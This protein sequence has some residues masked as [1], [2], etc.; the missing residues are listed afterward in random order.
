MY[1]YIACDIKIV[2]V[3]LHR[4]RHIALVPLIHVLKHSLAKGIRGRSLSPP[5]TAYGLVYVGGPNLSKN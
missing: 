2:F 5:Q 1:I 4:E 3:I